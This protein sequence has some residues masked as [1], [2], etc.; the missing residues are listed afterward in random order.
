MNGMHIMKFKV[1]LPS[2]KV[3]NLALLFFSSQL[4]I[5]SVQAQNY[6][7]SSQYMFNKILL[8][9]GYTGFN[10]QLEISTQ[11]KKQWVGF[12]GAPSS[13]IITA[14][15]PVTGKNV[16]LGVVMINDKIGVSQHQELSIN[17]AYRLLTSKGILSFGMNFGYTYASHSYEK[18]Q[19]S[20]I[21][22]PVFGQGER[23]YSP[24]FGF[25]TYFE[26]ELFYA[27]LSIMHLVNNSTFNAQTIDNSLGDK[28]HYYL[29]AGYTFAINQVQFLPSTM[30]KYTEGS[31]MEFD[32]NTNIYFNDYAGIGIT[33]KSLNA[34]SMLLALNIQNKMHIAYSYDIA[35]S[36]IRHVQNGSHEIIFRGIIQTNKKRKVYNPRF[37]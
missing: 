6:L 19:L 32:I 20:Q 33:Y 2:L 31:F 15:M 13:Q 9:P 27:G 11:I 25:G 26:S 1:T 36:K 24:N 17:Y 5:N 3:L 23:K 28:R 34:V 7:Y 8:N 16:G 35:T 30:I 14:Q 37:F 10:E 4:F 29:N 18:L 21:D 22:D 12:E